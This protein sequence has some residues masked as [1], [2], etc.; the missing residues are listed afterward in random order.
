MTANEILD[1]LNSYDG[2]N[3]W[4]DVIYRLDFDEDATDQLYADQERNS[5]YSDMVVIGGHAYRNI[6]GRWAEI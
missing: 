4:E 5:Y 3:I 2:D 6:A 1:Q